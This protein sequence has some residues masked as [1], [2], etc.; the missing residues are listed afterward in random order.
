M[1]ELSLIP[2]LDVNFGAISK[3]R[4][5]S[6]ARMCHVTPCTCAQDRRL[7]RDGVLLPFDFTKMK[8]LEKYV[9]RR[10]L[11]L[12]LTA[13]FQSNSNSEKDNVL[14]DPKCI[15][16]APFLGHFL[17]F[18]CKFCFG[19][20]LS[21][22]YLWC[23]NRLFVRT[24]H[25]ICLGWQSLSKWNALFSVLSVIPTKMDKNWETFVDI[26]ILEIK[27]YSVFQ[28]P[29]IEVIPSLMV[30]QYMA[31]LIM[32]ERVFITS[33]KN[34]NAGSHAKSMDLSVAVYPFQQILGS[35]STFS[36]H[37]LLSIHADS[38]I[39]F[40]LIIDCWFGQVTASVY[41]CALSVWKWFG[42]FSGQSVNPTA[43]IE[44]TLVHIHTLKIRN[45]LMQI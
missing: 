27:K 32:L 6:P 38:M 25:R 5:S 31:H 7:G 16:V 19:F 40:N 42:L 9:R 35:F 1:I 22:W 8:K 15:Q 34:A 44:L 24:S 28:C 45:F 23:E 30:S 3:G 43:K 4:C 17:P 10:Y 18:P 13:A 29:H 41:V 26:H 39:I 12:V 33:F 2:Q 37:L 21:W 14:A 11:I 36:L 20:M